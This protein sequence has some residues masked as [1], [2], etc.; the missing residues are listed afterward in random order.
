MIQM[1]RQY[2]AN[3]PRYYVCGVKNN[4]RVKNGLRNIQVRNRALKPM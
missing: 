4:V 3:V 2:K 1:L